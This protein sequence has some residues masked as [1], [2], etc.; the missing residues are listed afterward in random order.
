MASKLDIPTP[1]VVHYQSVDELKD[2]LAK[3]DKPK[4]VKLRRGCGAKGVFYANSSEQAVSMVNRLIERYNLL[5][6]NAIRWFRNVYRV[7]AGVCLASTGEVNGLPLL[8][9]GD[10]VRKP[11]TEGQVLCVNP[12]I[13]HH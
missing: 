9:T 12:R 5:P 10:C 3:T 2:I 8:R 6:E 4:V 7:K 11:S 1:R 13:T